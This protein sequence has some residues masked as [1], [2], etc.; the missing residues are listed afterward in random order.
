MSAT[1]ATLLP[2]VVDGPRDGVRAGTIVTLDALER[3]LADGL[4]EE[5]TSLIDRDALASLFQ[6]PAWC[7][8][9]YRCYADAFDPFVLLVRS[10]EALVGLVPMAVERGSRRLTFASDSMADYRD[11]VALPGCR[12]LVVDRLIEAYLEGSFP[13]PLQVGWL[14][15]ASTTRS[16]VEDVCRDRKLSYVVRHQPCHRWF[17]P[18]PSKP[19]AQKFLN[20]FK[21]QGEVSFDVI[22]SDESWPRFRDEY[23][24][25]HSL[26]QIQAGREL[27]FDDPRRTALYEQ[28]F[29]SKEVAPHVTAFTLDG[30]MLAGHFGYVWRGVLLLG[31]PAI[32]LEHER[33]SPAV[34][35]FAWI[36]QNAEALGLRGFDLTIGDS[37]FKRRLGN[38]CVDLT[39]VEVYRGRGSYL[40]RQIRRAVL[41]FAKRIV[42]RIAGPEA[43]DD[44]VKRVAG[45]LGYKRRRVA[46]E[47][48]GAALAA[49][50]R[51][52]VT[53]FVDVRRGH[54][55]AMRPTD[56]EPVTASLGPG[57][58]LEVHANRVEDLL[59]WK[60]RSPSTASAIAECARA[61]PRVRNVNGTLHTAVVSGALAGWGYSY[62]P[63]E[64]ARLT[65]TPGAV[66][67]FEPGAVSLYDFHVLREF[68]GRRIYQALLTHI[69]QQRFAEGAPVAHIS[70]LASNHS[71]R[72]AI[73]RV[74]FRLVAVN[75]YRRVLKWAT[76]RALP[77]R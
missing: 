20:W 45:W 60:G 6:T 14:D 15:P 28:L 59:L 3:A 41:G 24:R 57:V 19:S 26:R 21:R 48:V 9:W 5:W 16:L 49:A 1:A 31:P 46:E 42:A 23:Y 38:Q 73:E 2:T 68:R 55:Y 71:S 36:I 61:Y 4:R 22:E 10:Q 11:I 18:P 70:V 58:Q 56:L 54:V 29:H 50:G 43:W 74:G 47:G 35:L 40:R 64:P 33:R 67:E 51:A 63:K 52:A 75:A 76:L 39:A 17:P 53:A 13:N 69:L 32:R 25:L 8:A 62:Y 72:V 27:A 65:E 37:D 66:F 7:M 44:R 77:V 12:R 30:Q 34:I